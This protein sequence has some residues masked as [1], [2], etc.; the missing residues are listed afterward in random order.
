MSLKLG[1][2]GG[3]INFDLAF[4]CNYGFWR[5]TSLRYLSSFSKVKIPARKHLLIFFLFAFG[6]LNIY[7]N[8]EKS[9]IAE[10]FC[11]VGCKFFEIL[12][13]I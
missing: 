11:S 2:G 13:V 3:K 5:S 12:Q 6:C 1:E 4:V 9:K 10:K 7:L 8:L